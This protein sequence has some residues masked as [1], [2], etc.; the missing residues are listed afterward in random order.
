MKYKCAI[1]K[2]EFGTDWPEEEAEAELAE[3]FPG[4]DK[5]DCDV[6]CDDCYKQHF[7]PASH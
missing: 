1:C 5:Q 6:V 4:Y 3:N 2:E 7:E